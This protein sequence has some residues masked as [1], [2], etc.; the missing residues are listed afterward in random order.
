MS[1]PLPQSF[2][3]AAAAG[4][5]LATSPLRGRARCFTMVIITKSSH[6]TPAT[7][8]LPRASLPMNPIVFA[9]KHPITVV[10]A[11]VGVLVGSALALTRMKIDIFPNL[12][13]PVIYVVQPYGGMDPAQMEGLLT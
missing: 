11:L 6:G 2:N 1:A 3:Q 9:L 8:R 5:I 12:N 10:V 7:D 4:R 13:L